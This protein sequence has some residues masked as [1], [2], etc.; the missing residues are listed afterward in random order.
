MASS[1]PSDLGELVNQQQAPPSSHKAGGLEKEIQNEPTDSGWN[2]KQVAKDVAKFSP[3]AIFNYLASGG[4]AY[5]TGGASFLSS[6]ASLMSPIGYMFGRLIE[7]RKAKKK[8]TWYQMRKELG[9]GNFVGN[10]AYWVYQIPEFLNISTATWGGKI[11]RSL[12]FNPGM[13]MPF[14][15][16][17][18]TAVYLRDKIGTRNALKGLYNGKIFS[19]IKEAY[20]NKLKKDYWSDVTKTFATLFPIHLYSLNFVKMPA[21]RVGIGAMNDILFRLIAGRPEGNGQ[22]L[23][24]QKVETE[25]PVRAKYEPLGKYKGFKEKLDHFFRAPGYEPFSYQPAMKGAH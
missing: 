13:L 10:L 6:T 7:N 15:A 25:Q 18:Q 14:I 22:Q 19:Y 11:L 17:Y 8:T 23:K 4:L 12:S 24:N 20:R 21:L 3:F 2:F 1:K 5:L 16:L 9:T